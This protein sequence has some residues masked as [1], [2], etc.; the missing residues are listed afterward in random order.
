MNPDPVEEGALNENGEVVDVGVT[1]GAPKE[2]GDAV[3]LVVSAAAFC[4]K[5]KGL[6]EV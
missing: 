6:E 3:G 2:N 4:P 5:P 1:D